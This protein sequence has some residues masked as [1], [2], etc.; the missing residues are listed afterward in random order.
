[1]QVKTFIPNL[2]YLYK[3]THQTAV[4]WRERMGSATIFANKDR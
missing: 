3:K 1:M 2:I 4:V